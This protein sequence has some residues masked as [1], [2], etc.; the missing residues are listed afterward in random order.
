MCEDTVAPSLRLHVTTRFS[1]PLPHAVEHGSHSP[2]EKSKPHRFVPV[3]KRISSGRGPASA[4]HLARLAGWLETAL[5]QVTA[6]VMLAVPVVVA[7]S[8]VSFLRQ[9]SDPGTLSTRVFCAHR[10]VVPATTQKVTTD[11]VRTC[12]SLGRTPHPLPSI[13]LPTSVSPSSLITCVL[14]LRATGIQPVPRL[15]QSRRQLHTPG[16]PSL[17]Q[18]ALLRHTD[19]SESVQGVLTTVSSVVCD[20]YAAF[21]SYLSR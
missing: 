5:T 6:R 11:S 7:L 17:Q 19:S 4:W 13:H 14:L 21:L 18:P 8:I 10:S 12:L 15:Q 9:G 20:S 1:T 2:A 3:T 16:G